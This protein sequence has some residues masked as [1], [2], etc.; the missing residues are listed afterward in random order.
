MP[1]ADNKIKKVIDRVIT[2][3]NAITAGANYH[4][5]PYKVTKRFIHWAEADG[6][7]TYMVH[8]DSGGE[9][10][11]SGEQTWDLTFYISVKGIVD[12][13][14]SG[15]DVEN[16]VDPLVYAWRDV[17]KAIDDDAKS[18]SVNT[19]G[20]LTVQVRIDEP[21]ETDNGYLALEGF[22]FFDQRIRVQ[23]T[24]EFGTL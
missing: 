10:E 9:V 13:S 24:G 17:T 18:P 5:T 11:Y 2:V 8:L 16:T 23:I 19:L 7:P 22:G 6:F 14:L 15:G 1:P 12:T 21:P 3:L 4:Y 20:D